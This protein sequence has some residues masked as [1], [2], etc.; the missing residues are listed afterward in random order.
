MIFHKK[1]ILLFPIMLVMIG[2]LCLNLHD[3]THLHPHQ[4]DS[5]QTDSDSVPDKKMSDDCVLCIV[6]ASG[7]ADLEL[8]SF[9]TVQ[10]EAERIL[11]SGL[12]SL[13]HRIIS[14]TAPRAPPVS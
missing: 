6:S 4:T 7:F 12:I 11:P 3:L 9:K 8:Q 14:V 13:S 5:H 1:Y 2:F 10:T